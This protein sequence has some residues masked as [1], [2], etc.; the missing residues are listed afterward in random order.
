MTKRRA[1]RKLSE[2]SED[3][4]TRNKKRIK[5]RAKRIFKKEREEDLVRSE[6]RLNEDREEH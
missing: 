5:R 6:R 3:E 4:Y 1:R 2:N